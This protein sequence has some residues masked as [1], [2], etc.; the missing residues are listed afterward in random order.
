[1]KTYWLLLYVVLLLLSPGSAFAQEEGTPTVD[2]A[3]SWILSTSPSP[4]E[5]MIGKKPAIQVVFAEPP[6]PGTL[7]VVLDG[8][9]ITQMITPSENGFTYKPVFVMAPGTHELS[10]SA[11]DGTGNPLQ[12]SVSFKTRHTA[13]FEEATLNADMTGLYTST[14]RKE[15]DDGTTPYN[16]VTVEGSVQ[17]KLREGANEL[18]F[19]GSPVYVEQDKP[20]SSGSVEKGLDLRSFVIRGEH[21]GDKLQG[22]VELG[23]VQVS[24]TPFTVQGLLRRGAKFNLGYG[25]GALSF[26][27]VRAPAI[28]GVRHTLG[29]KYDN[30]SQ[31]TGGSAGLSLPG[32]RTDIKAT[33]LTGEDD[34]SLTYGISGIETGLRKGDVSSLRVTTQ[35]IPTALVADF[36]AAYSQYDFDDADEFDEVSD[37]AWRLDLS[38]TVNQYTYDLKYE[39][40]GRDFESIAIQGGT[41]DREGIY[42]MGNAMFPNHSVSILASAFRDNVDSLAIMPRTINI[43]LSLDYNYT[44]FPEVPMGLSVQ[45]SIL[46]T[47]DEP[48]SFEPVETI[49]D[50]ITGKIAYTQPKWNTGFSTSYSYIN[51][52]TGADLDTSNGNYTLSLTLTPVET[53][54]LSIVPN[55]VQQKNEATDVRTD[56][57]TTTVDLRSQLIK[58]LIYWDLGGSYS[59]TDTT[60]DSVDTETTSVNTRLAYS[61]KRYFPTQLNP[62]IALKGNYQKTKDKVADT[63]TDNL[64]VFLVFELQAKFGL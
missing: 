14:L 5:E 54:S 13:S 30:D 48:S 35:I 44:R 57:Y 23:D 32:L 59:T 1:M 50:T 22:K 45:H 29:L 2:A 9:D 20:L 19:E 10:V 8:T 37:T 36:E 6:A 7:V 51:D 55:L 12:A 17:G 38:G 64:T 3:K 53:W 47:T 16:A 61:L 60:D 43:P 62:T 33:Y 56:T 18:S 25:N 40:Y 63:E 41:K 34:S 11:A 52:R 24:E 15:S 4:N 21:K 28:Y 49:S 58:E 42:F 39:Y 31:I 46:K 27:S 26:F